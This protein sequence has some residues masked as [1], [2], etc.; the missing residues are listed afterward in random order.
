MSG[1]NEE[2]DELIAAQIGLVALYQA[3]AKAARRIIVVLEGRDATGKDGT[4]KR[5][6]GHLPTRPV[7]AVSLAP[8]NER[9]RSSWYFQRYIAQFP[10]GGEIVIFNRS[11]YNRAGVE[12][13]MGFCTED[14]TQVFLDQVP[15]FEALLVESG[16]ELVKYYLDI[17][18]DEQKQRLEARADD[19]LKVWKI[20]PLDAKALEKFD[21]Y[22]ERRDRMLTRT[23]TEA[24][25]WTV[26]RANKKSR[27]RLNLIR[28]LVIRLAPDQAG[29]A[30]PVDREVVRPF[31]ASALTDGFLSR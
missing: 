21:A 23:S 18:K 7:R 4:I 31:D 10:A 15:R 24:A 28:D 12:P 22:S 11:W 17:S 29:Q 3:V 16:F 5:I 6:T 9:E 25:P 19:P 27:A 26:V 13:V 8:P 30:G 2:D 14:Q 1:K 20:G